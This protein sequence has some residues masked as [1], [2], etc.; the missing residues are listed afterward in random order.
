[1][2]E[3]EILNHNIRMYIYKGRKYTLRKLANHED[4]TVGY[5][6]LSGRLNQGILHSDTSHWDSIKQCMVA[7]IVIGRVR[8]KIID[9]PLDIID[10]IDPLKVL[11]IGS[12]WKKARA[13]Q[14]IAFLRDCHT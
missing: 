11:P 5:S 2:I 12:L 7:K 14:S 6:T 3:Y 9:K 8:K 13:M 4:C 1:M 10:Y